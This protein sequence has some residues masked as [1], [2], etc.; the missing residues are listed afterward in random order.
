[1]DRSSILRSDSHNS[2]QLNRR[3]SSSHSMHLHS[4]NRSRS[5]KLFPHTRQHNCRSNHSRRCKRNRQ[6]L[7]RLRRLAVLQVPNRPCRMDTRLLLLL[8]R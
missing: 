5:C 8:Q 2:N 6:W 1:M 3:T 7:R 4:F